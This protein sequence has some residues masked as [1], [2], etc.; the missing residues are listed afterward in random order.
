VFFRKISGKLATPMTIHVTM[1]MTAIHRPICPSLTSQNVKA[2]PTKT[3]AAQ[4]Q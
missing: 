3:N 2:A 1:E 4:S